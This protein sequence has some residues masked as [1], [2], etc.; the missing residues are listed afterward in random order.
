LGKPNDGAGVQRAAV[1]AVFDAHLQLGQVSLQIAC[2][3]TH[4]YACPK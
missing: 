2:N 3:S 1:A 4:I